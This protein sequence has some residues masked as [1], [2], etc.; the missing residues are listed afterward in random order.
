MTY[1][2]DTITSLF[3]SLLLELSRE[4]FVEHITQ[5]LF[6]G[7]IGFSLGSTIGSILGVT[8]STYKSHSS[9]VRFLVEILRPIPPITWIAPAIGWFGLGNTS[10]IFI[11]SLGAFFPT[12]SAAQY[13]IRS[14]NQ[15]HIDL[16]RV[17][18]AGR[19]QILSR[20]YLPASLPSIFS[21]LRVAMGVSWMCLIAAEM[22]GTQSG[23]GYMIQ[24]KRLTLDGYGMTIYMM[25][26]GI[27]G[28]SMNYLLKLMEIRLTP[29][30]QT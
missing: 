3:D 12:F 5:S 23:L 24:I 13:C 15:E 28:A 22:I 2:W 21:S 16:A 11:I 20:I 8:T 26:I 29:W 6:R 19:L 27:I 10:A 4:T 14:I 17:L 18:G 1:T 30:N 9:F 25:I 7:L